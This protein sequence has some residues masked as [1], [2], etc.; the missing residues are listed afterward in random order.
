MERVKVFKNNKSQAVRLPKPVSLPDTVKEVDIIR[1]G[2]SRL[3]APAGEAWDS[4]FEGAGVRR[5]NRSDA[6]VHAGHQYSY[7]HRKE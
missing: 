7:L 2:R 5:G 1:L 3:I 4:W 6:Q